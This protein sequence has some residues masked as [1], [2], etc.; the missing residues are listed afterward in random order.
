MKRLAFLALTTSLLIGA[1]AAQ[2]QTPSQAPTATLDGR[3]F[4]STGVTDGGAARALAP[5][6][7]IRLIFNADGSLGASAG[8]N[9]IGGTYRIDNGVLRAQPGAMTE[10]GCDPARHAQDDWLVK[11]LASGPSVTLAGNDLLL[12]AGDTAVRLLDREVADPDLPLTGTLWTVDSVQDDDA[13]SSVP[14]GGQAQ[15]TLRIA[16][17]GSAVFNNGCNEGG[18][19]VTVDGDQIRFIDVVTTD[20][21]CPDA[22]GVMEKAVMAVLG[23][24]TVT[25]SIEAGHLTLTAGSKSL[26]LQG[27]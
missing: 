5:N 26:G 22:A 6:T 4:L 7:R 15:A 1:C 16:A 8:C 9:S 23:A 11:F 10:M 25:W 27:S 14:D 24:N 13:V 18:A 12:E 3:T 19:R 17:D 20:R 2:A 21:A